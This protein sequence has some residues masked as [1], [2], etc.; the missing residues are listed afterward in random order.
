MRT[1]SRILAVYQVVGGIASLVA[2]AGTA[3]QTGYFSFT[4]LVIASLLGICTGLFL[5]T[6]EA[7]GWRWTVVNQCVQIV[8][9]YVPLFAFCI[10]QGVSFITSFHYFQRATFA[11]SLFRNSI[12]VSFLPVCDALLKARPASF[13]TYG[14]SINWLAVGLAV[15]AM[16]RVKRGK[17][18]IRSGA[19][20]LSVAAHE[21]RA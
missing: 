6:R 19:E 13:P 1:S 7:R 20:Q 18:G 12:G 3:W 21:S 4:V 16:Y 8:G 14:L 10:V 9:V 11:D 15:F 17:P 2:L 5:W